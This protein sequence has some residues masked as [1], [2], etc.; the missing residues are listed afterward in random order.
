MEKNKIF[1]SKIIILGGLIILIFYSVFYNFDLFEAKNFFIASTEWGTVGPKYPPR[2]LIASV[3]DFE[4][5]LSWV[6]P[7]DP[8]GVLG[9][10]VYRCENYS[11]CYPSKELATVN[12]DVFTYTDSVILSSTQYGYAIRAYGVGNL[13]PMSNIVHLT[14]NKFWI[15]TYI[16][17]SLSISET[18][19]PTTGNVVQNT[20]NNTVETITNT[21]TITNNQTI[22]FTE[23]MYI[24]VRSDQ[25]KQLQ[26]L[27]AKYP[28]IYPEGKI[29]GYFWTATYKA[30]GRFQ[31]KYGIV[32]SS[33]SAGYGVVGPK[34]REKLNEIA[35]Q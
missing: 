19:T 1:F 34:T 2:D 9:Y 31:I 24:G 35:N 30:V 11:E 10:K 32:A 27:L 28:D 22:N 8:S 7:Q 13:S 6:A 5:K 29:T 23:K 33:T 12:S 25:V 21:T 16:D 20:T 17:N 4:I 14:S 3:S 18:T 26:T 15:N